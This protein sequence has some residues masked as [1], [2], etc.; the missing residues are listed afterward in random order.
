MLE[1][2]L[3]NKFLETEVSQKVKAYVPLLKIAKFSWGVLIPINVQALPLEV[4]V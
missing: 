4:L 1:I 2:G 3:Q